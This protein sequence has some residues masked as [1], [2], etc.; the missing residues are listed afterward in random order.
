MCRQVQGVFLWSAAHSLEQGSLHLVQ[1]IF[2]QAL[3]ETGKMVIIL[4][5]FDEISP[6]YT[7]KVNILIRAIRDTNSL[8]DIGFILLFSPAELGGHCDKTGLHV[9]TLHTRKSD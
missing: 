2:L 3:E 8:K 7:P 1:K 6:Y 4:D 9:T 5:G